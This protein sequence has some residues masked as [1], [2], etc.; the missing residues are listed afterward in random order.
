MEAKQVHV[1]H[2]VPGL[3]PGGM[4]MAMARMIS[5]IQS[6]DIRHTI[7]CLKG[8]PLIRDQFPASVAIECLRSRPNDPLLPIRLRRLIRRVRPTVIHAR[9]WGAWPDVALARLL[10][11]PRVPLVFSFHGFASPGRLPLRRRLAFRVLSRITTHPLT[12]CDAARTMLIDQFGWPPD[13]VRVIPNGVDVARFSPSLNGRIQPDRLVIG[14]VGNLTP[15]KNHRLLIQAIAGLIQT[16]VSCDLRIAGEGPERTNLEQLAAGLGVSSH[17]FFPGQVDDIPRF[18]RGLDLFVLPSTSEAHPNA[19]LEAMASGLPCVATA[20][21]GVPEVLNSGNAGV[22]VAPDDP[23][24][25]ADSMRELCT[26][27]K[28]RK[29]LGMAARRRVEERYSMGQMADAYA[30]LYRE[31]S[32][33]VHAAS[34]ATDTAALP[35]ARLRVLQLGPLPPLVGGMATVANNLLQ[36]PLAETVDL[37]GINNGKT[38]PEGRPLSAGVC[39]QWRLLTEIVRTVR[40][41]RVQVV[42]IHTCALFAF[43]RDIVHMMAV[44]LLG[45]RVVWHLHDGTFPQFISQGNPLKR[46]LIRWALARGSATIVL[47]DEALVRLRPHAPRV[48]WRVVPNGVV[49]KAPSDKSSQPPL[50][51]LF[52]GNLTHRKGAYDLISAVEAAADRGVRLV[53]LLAGGEAAPGQRAAIEQRIAGSPCADRLRLLGLIQGEEKD[54]AIA[55]ADCVVL[56]SYAEGLPM[57]LLE[58]MAAGL[59]AVATRVGSVSTIITDGVEGFLI[60]PA[61]VASLTDRICRLAGDAE[62]CQRMGQAARTRIQEQF[63]LNVMAER[64]HRIYAEAVGEDSR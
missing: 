23:K 6:A 42:H 14:A 31:A 50:T 36:S 30:R 48:R 52:M 17:V 56:P 39:A 32:V 63:S 16:G 53:V 21:G 34:S 44:R 3:E 58:G 33:G 54:K 2:V 28:A 12:V 46:G 19:L 40:R 57:V 22:L 26:S 27:P 25:L 43:W 24:S 38:T 20:V 60:E 13:R 61:D 8:E 4:E 55:E 49:I 15:V 18:L 62:L 41:R 5:A 64:V 37:V 59:P 35:T 47:S 11:R 9:N 51:L 10:V 7:V 45:C 29:S 1:L